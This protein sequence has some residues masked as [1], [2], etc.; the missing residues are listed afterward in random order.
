MEQGMVTPLTIE[1]QLANVRQALETLLQSKPFRGQ[2]DLIR[3]TRAQLT[4]L[5]QAY[6]KDIAEAEPTN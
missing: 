2:E 5:L 4:L 1:Q 3:D 6:R